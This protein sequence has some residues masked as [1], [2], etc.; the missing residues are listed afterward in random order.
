[1]NRV[2]KWFVLV[3]CLALPMPWAEGMPIPQVIHIEEPDELSRDAVFMGGATILGLVAFGSLLNLMVSHSA[4][5]AYGR[6][7]ITAISF[8]AISSALGAIFLMFTAYFSLSELGGV[9]AMYFIA[10]GVLAVVLGALSTW[11]NSFKNLGRRD[12]TTSRRTGG[13]PF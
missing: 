10:G 8:G 12:P 4:K 7:A 1:M 2:M 3:A 9:Q 6:G 11:L 5:P 13:S